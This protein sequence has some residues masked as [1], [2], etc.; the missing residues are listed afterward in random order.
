[1]EDLKK[2]NQDNKLTLEKEHQKCLELAVSKLASYMD[3]ILYLFVVY[4]LLCVY[5]CTCDYRI[6]EYL[7]F[8]F[9]MKLQSFSWLMNR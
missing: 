8:N 4:Q 3:V 5:S 1:M 7:L 2:E 6:Y 9:R